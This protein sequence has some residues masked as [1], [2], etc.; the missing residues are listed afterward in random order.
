MNVTSLAKAK[1]KVRGKVDKNTARHN[2]EKLSMKPG[3][4]PT[5]ILDPGSPNFALR[6][7]SIEPELDQSTQ[8]KSEEEDKFKNIFEINNCFTNNLQ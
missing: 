6:T 1:G 7:I 5:V 2:R 3:D 4:N 8:S